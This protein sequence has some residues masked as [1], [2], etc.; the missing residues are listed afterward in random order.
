MLVRIAAALNYSRRAV[1]I[2]LLL[3][4]VVSWMVGRGSGT[5]GDSPRNLP[6]VSEFRDAR[7]GFSLYSGVSIFGFTVLEILAIVIFFGPSRPLGFPQPFMVIGFATVLSL[8]LSYV[9]TLV[10]SAFRSS[11]TSGVDVYGEPFLYMWSTVC[12]VFVG[13]SVAVLSSLVLPPWGEILG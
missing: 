6:V 3:L 11:R 1:L 9:S 13:S 7:Q 8:L 5:N 12:G 2:G 4:R 10:E